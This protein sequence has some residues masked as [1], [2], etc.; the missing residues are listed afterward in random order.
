VTG[1][2]C[3]SPGG[4]GHESS[5]PGGVLL[6]V[7]LSFHHHVVLDGAS[8]SVP[9][10]GVT[11]LMGANG[12]GKTTL[13][14]CILGQYP[15]AG[16]VTWKGQRIRP[17]RRLVYPVFDDCSF[18]LNGSGA[19]N[20]RLLGFREPGS[21]ASYLSPETLSRPVREYSLGQRKRLALTAALGSGAEWLLLDE[22]TTGLDYEAMVQF[23]R[24]L[25]SLA[26]RCAVLVTG[27]HVEFYDDLVQTVLVLREG[28]LIEV[29]REHWVEEGGTGLA[30]VYEKFCASS[31]R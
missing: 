31:A 4:V 7:G 26:A 14:R 2:G 5:P 27:H 6:N 15:H 22:P 25:T 24:D 28:R 19:T 12:S 29:A 13:M 18:Y 16:M 10:C 21:S 20:L 3:N 17:G 1:V 9:G 30:G 23:R 8:A 11:F